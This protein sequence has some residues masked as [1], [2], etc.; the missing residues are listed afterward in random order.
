MKRR[1]EKGFA[2]LPV[3]LAVMIL[4]A[5]IGVGLTVIVPRIKKE[6]YNQS[7]AAMDAAVQAII[8]WAATNERLPTSAAFPSVVK[9]TADAWRKTLLYVY[10]NTLTSLATGG[11]C[12]RQTTAI[13]SGTTGNIAFLIISGGDDYAV[14]STPNTSGQYSGNV[15]VS[16]NDIV[17]LVTLEQLKNTA[18]CYAATGTR[19]RILNN[20]LPQACAG[21]PYTA[22]LYG[23]GGM[24]F[25]GGGDYKWCLKG[26]L[27]GGLASVPNTP[28][29]P[30]TSDC[31]SLG[32]EASSQWSQ[33]DSL[34]ISGTPAAGGTYPVVVLVRDNNDNNTGTAN[35]NC[36]QQ[37]FSITVTT[38]P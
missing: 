33:A 36:V 11:I 26:S 19:L 14:N 22:T 25:S 17:K 38:C 10:D 18:G 4:G 7:H 32:T 30:S 37:A 29:C 24:P 15:T 3:I 31:A 5:L 21:Q 28:G 8:S 23:E 34:Q 35:D 12:G 16:L 9:T 13:T 27:P 20:E 6:K 2:L 1:K